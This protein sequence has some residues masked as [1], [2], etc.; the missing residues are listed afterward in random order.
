MRMRSRSTARKVTSVCT[1]LTRR[2]GNGAANGGFSPVGS[3]RATPLPRGGGF[4]YL[5]TVQAGERSLRRGRSGGILRK[6]LDAYNR[7]LRP[8]SRHVLDFAL[9]LVDLVL[10]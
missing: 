7:A 9:V 10:D 8:F 6:F 2:C 3:I 5:Q 4:L 1:R